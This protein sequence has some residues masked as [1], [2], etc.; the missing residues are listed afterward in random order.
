[1]KFKSVIGEQ[2]AANFIAKVNTGDGQRFLN[3]LGMK[4]KIQCKMPI[5]T[6]AIKLVTQWPAQ[7]N[8]CFYYLVLFFSRSLLIGH[9]KM[10]WEIVAGRGAF[11]LRLRCTI[12]LFPHTGH[13]LHHGSISVLLAKFPSTGHSCEFV[14]EWIPNGAERGRKRGNLINTNYCWLAILHLVSSN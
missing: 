11:R 5:C 12:N 3:M 10:T 6:T 1:M 13:L 14:M 4:N 7:N 2:F 9:Y 8:S